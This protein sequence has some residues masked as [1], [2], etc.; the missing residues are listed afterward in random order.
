M[1]RIGKIKSFEDLFVW[2]KAID[3]S[4][5]VYTITTAFPKNEMFGLTA[6][7][8]NASNS[9]S[10]NIS[11]GSVKSTKSYVN[12]L[13][14]ANGSAS[15]VLSAGILSNRL[16]YL[17]ADPLAELRIKVGEIKKMLKSLITTLENQN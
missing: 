11:E 14:I 1:E 13:T 7:I 10:L 15:E 4:V 3:L 2:Q 17:E 5:F 9:I 8:R 6:Q 16:G 12:H